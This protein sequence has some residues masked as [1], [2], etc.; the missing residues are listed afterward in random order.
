MENIDSFSIDLGL[1][2][3]CCDMCPKI[4]KLED[5]SMEQGVAATKAKG[6]TT[7]T[8][9]DTTSTAASAIITTESDLDVGPA[10][11]CISSH[12]EHNVDA[13]FFNQVQFLNCL[14]HNVSIN[15]ILNLPKILH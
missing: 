3:K 1:C 4:P 10:T 9:K 2:R 5:T 7:T 13:P 14:P 6:I 11:S 8:G 15:G 12:G